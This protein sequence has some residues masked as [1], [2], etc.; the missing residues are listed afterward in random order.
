MNDINW[1]EKTKESYNDYYKTYRAAWCRKSGL[2]MMD[3]SCWEKIQAEDLYTV[4]RAKKKHISIDMKKV[5]GWY[6]IW[7]GYVPM[8]KAVRKGKETYSN[9][10]TIT[11]SD[12][13]R[14]EECDEPT[15][16]VSGF[17]DGADENGG[18]TSGCFYD[19]DNTE[20]AIKQDRCS[21]SAEETIFKLS[22]H[23]QNEA[24]STSAAQLRKM[25]LDAKVSVGTAATLAGVTVSEY[26]AMEAEKKPLPIDVYQTLRLAFFNA[27]LLCHKKGMKES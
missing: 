12:L 22:V 18:D 21:E 13:K 1:L 11:S 10:I 15:K 9:T 8:F 7:Q 4:S 20:C 16:R 2:P 5:C 26:S 25:R 23:A 6:R 3:S 17:W 14:C 24:A 27:K 19:C